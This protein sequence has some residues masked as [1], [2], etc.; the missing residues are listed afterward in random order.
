L[1][2]GTIAVEEKK[3]RSVN[4]FIPVFALFLFFGI[5]I[6]SLLMAILYLFLDVTCLD[7]N[8]I[9]WAGRGN[10]VKIHITCKYSI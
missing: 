3:V 2:L 9:E 6:A 5:S 4:W 8:C 1:L 10:P 7:T